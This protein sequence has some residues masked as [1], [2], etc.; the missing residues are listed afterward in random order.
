MIVT[1][2]E[3]LM[4]PEIVTVPVVKVSPLIA[5]LPVIVVVPVMETPVATIETVSLLLRLQLVH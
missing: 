3:A 5:T 1:V 2:P 4:L